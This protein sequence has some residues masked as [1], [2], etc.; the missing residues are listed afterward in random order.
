MRLRRAVPLVVALVAVAAI[1]AALLSRA[2]AEA[3]DTGVVIDVDAGGLTDVRAFTIRTDDGRQATYRIGDLENGAEFPPGH[4]VEHIATSE[5]ILVY[6]REEVGDRVAY[7][8]ED[9]PGG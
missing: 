2:G 6:Y 4:L 5:P 7:R 8:L 9:A 1:A 3:T